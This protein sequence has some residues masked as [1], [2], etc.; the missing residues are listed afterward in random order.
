MIVS[1]ITEHRYVECRYAERRM[2]LS[3]C[4]VSKFTVAFIIVMLRDVVMLSV[5]TPSVV[6]P[7]Q[8]NQLTLLPSKTN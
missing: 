1:I 5:I 3:L 4:W 6:A 7:T 2:L 8:P